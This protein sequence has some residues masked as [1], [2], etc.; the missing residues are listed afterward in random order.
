MEVPVRRVLF[1]TR[2][3][4]LPVGGLKSGGERWRRVQR[5]RRWEESGGG[6]W[7][8]GK[9]WERSSLHSAALCAESCTL[10]CHLRERN[11]E[12]HITSKEG[13]MTVTETLLIEQ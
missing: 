3:L 13:E 4:A 6:W 1:V 11:R 9:S 12:L 5:G 8:V 10:L 7:P 2:A